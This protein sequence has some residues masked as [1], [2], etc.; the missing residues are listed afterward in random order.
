MVKDGIGNY[1]LASA[2][3]NITIMIYMKTSVSQ[4]LIYIK[5]I[6][7]F[8]KIK[9]IAFFIISLFNQL[10]VSVGILLRK[11]VEITEKIYNTTLSEQF[12]NLIGKS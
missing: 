4:R 7:I 12:L 2:L 11:I 6:Y 1:I 5:N 8:I 9:I 10:Y 3:F